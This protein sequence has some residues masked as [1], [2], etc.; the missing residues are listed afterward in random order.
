MAIIT[1]PSYIAA[2]KKLKE[3]YAKLSWYKRFWFSISSYRLW[4]A[5]WAI[6]LDNPK[7]QP[8]SEQ[9]AAL[10][11]ASEESW[12]FKSIFGLLNLLHDFSFDKAEE[13]TSERSTQFDALNSPPQIEP[14][15]TLTPNPFLKLP[16]PLVDL[17]LD[18]L[19]T[20]DLIDLSAGI[21]FFWPK[22]DAVKFLLHVVHGDYDIVQKM[23]E[24]DPSLLIRKG[25]VTDCSERTFLNISG[26]EYALWALD[27]HMWTKMLACLPQNE[28]GQK[29]KQTLSEQ[30]EIVKEQGVCY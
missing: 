15:A 2:L 12:F 5:L 17:V 10:N 9:I 29:I 8:T 30:Y 22:L 6:E 4:R 25:D 13:P 24:K 1:S 27:K 28:E 14:A 11:A 16:N 26:F 21:S 23:L 19:P 18:Y 7:N 3:D 20:S